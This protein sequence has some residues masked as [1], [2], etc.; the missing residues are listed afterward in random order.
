ME[1]LKNSIWHRRF[2]ARLAGLLCAF[3]AASTAPAVAGMLPVCSGGDR[4][5]RHLTCIVDGDTGWE[6]GRKWRLKD[7]DAPELSEH[8]ICRAEARKAIEARDRLRALM[9]AG[10]TI[11][12]TGIKG[13]YHRDI[14]TITLRDGRNAGKELLRE[15]LAQSWPNGGDAVWCR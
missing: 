2:L 15:G 6:N 5:A 1:R 9:G 10:Y 3:A 11:N 14:V 7:I 8:A 12:W 4:A 13:Y